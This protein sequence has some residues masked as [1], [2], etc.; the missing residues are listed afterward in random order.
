MVLCIESYRHKNDI[1]VIINGYSLEMGCVL[2]P[3]APLIHSRLSA[4]VGRSGWQIF[5]SVGRALEFYFGGQGSNPDRDVG[6]FQ[7][8]HHFLVTNFHIRKA[9]YTNDLA[10]FYT[11]D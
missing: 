8:M 2:C 5:G 11:V 9:C 1:L 4:V 10:S 6:F 7:T 3:I